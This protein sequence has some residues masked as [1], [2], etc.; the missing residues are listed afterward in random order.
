MHKPTA[1]EL[2]LAKIPPSRVSGHHEGPNRK[3]RRAE[4]ANAKRPLPK[5]IWLITKAYPGIHIE[6]RTPLYHLTIERREQRDTITVFSRE[7][8]APTEGGL[9]ERMSR[10]TG[11][12]A[13]IWTDGRASKESMGGGY[14]LVAVPAEW[15]F[16]RPE[17]NPREYRF[18]NVA[19]GEPWPGSDYRQA[20]RE[21]FEQ[22]V[23]RIGETYFGGVAPLPFGEP[24]REVD[25]GTDGRIVVVGDRK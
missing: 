25:R 12:E 7:G 11:G 2:E 22:N 24:V 3:Q 6:T 13:A 19:L 14:T 10:P 15:G 9:L 20:T 8:A 23:A 4:A 1:A 21:E 5:S 18:T 16:P 17:V